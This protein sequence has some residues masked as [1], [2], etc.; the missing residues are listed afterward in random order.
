MGRIQQHYFLR[1]FV[2][3]ALS[4]QRSQNYLKSPP[5]SYVSKQL[6]TSFYALPRGMLV[7]RVIYEWWFTKWFIMPLNHR[8]LWSIAF[9]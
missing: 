3:C 5:N 2:T 1:R 4:V 6:T 8:N 9:I 7:E